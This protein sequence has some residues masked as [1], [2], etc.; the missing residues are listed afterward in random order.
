MLSIEVLCCPRV[1]TVC[2]LSIVSPFMTADFMLTSDVLESLSFSFVFDFSPFS[3]FASFFTALCLDTVSPSSSIVASF[4]CDVLSSGWTGMS[5]A[6][7]HH[8]YVYNLIFKGI[9]SKRFFYFKRIFLFCFVFFCV[10]FF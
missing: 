9:C 7:I 4:A 5:S 10:F 6:K 1:T 8:T 2:T 3:F